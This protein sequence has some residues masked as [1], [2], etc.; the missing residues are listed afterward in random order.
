MNTEANYLLDT[1]AMIFIGTNHT[2]RGVS[3]NALN[4]ATRAGRVWLSA[5]SALE[6]GLLTAKGRLRLS[7]SPLNFFEGIQQTGGYRLSDLAPR[8]LVNA[9]YLPDFAH[10]DPADRIIIATAREYDLTIVTRDEA[11]LRYGQ[12]GYVKTLAC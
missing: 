7:V 10:N 11:I 6:I 12:S 8:I 2:L 5:I 9:S 1:C 3:E 4:Y